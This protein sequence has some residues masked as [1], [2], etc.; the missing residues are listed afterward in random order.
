MASRKHD[1]VCSPFCH[2]AGLIMAAVGDEAYERCVVYAANEAVPP[3][4]QHCRRLPQ[5]HARRHPLR[6]GGLEAIH[7]EA[8]R[9]GGGFGGGEE[10]AEFEGMDGRRRTVREWEFET[11]GCSEEGIE[12]CR[13][14]GE[15]DG[16]IASQ[17][18]QI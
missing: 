2:E 11:F 6:R 10:G 1:P 16:E 15:R 17:L 13:R 18:Q 7:T 3:T 4:P 9:L 8:L 12:M 14:F 5:H